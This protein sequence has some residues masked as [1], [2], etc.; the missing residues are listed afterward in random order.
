MQKL[1]KDNTYGGKGKKKKEKKK[2]KNLFQ[3]FSRGTRGW[4][5]KEAMEAQKQCK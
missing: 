1:H 5:K 4:M 3:L 2:K